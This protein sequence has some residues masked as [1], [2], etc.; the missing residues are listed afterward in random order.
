[1]ST[2]LNILTSISVIIFLNF[3]FLKKNFLLD[4]KKLF[5]KSFTSKDPVPLTGGFV[6][7]LCI[8]MLNNIYWIFFFLIFFIGILSDLL[9]IKNAIKK[10]LIQFLIISVYLYFS[11]IR[12]LNTKINFLD[13]LLRYEIFSYLF[14][15]TCLLILMNGSNFMDG[16]NTLVCGYYIIVL[17]FIIYL[18]EKN[19][20]VYNFD[21]YYFLLI[22]LIVV[23]LFNSLSKIYLGDAGSFLLSFIIGHYLIELFN[24]NL[25]SSTPIPSLFIILLLWYPAFENLFSILRKIINKKSPVKPDNLHLHQLLFL[26]LKKKKQLNTNFLNTLTGCI[27]NIFNIFVFIIGSQ[28]YYNVK[29][30]FIL[31]CFNIFLYIN[32][33][34]Y[35]KAKLN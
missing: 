31:I 30:L 34:F 12:I 5:H 28:F 9:V 3:F 6:I 22:N 8:F 27:I 20:F 19:N 10:F 33:Y 1:M 25:N 18:G 35:F 24:N 16:V 13:Y 15:A 29:F 26:F 2:L 7:I 32:A 21:E 17:L 23:F 4:K 14:I 11:E